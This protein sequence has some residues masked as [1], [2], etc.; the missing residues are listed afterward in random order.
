MSTTTHRLKTHPAAFYAVRDGLKPFEVRRNDR[1]F[2]SGDLVEL[3]YWDP[4]GE[5]NW[6]DVDK[7]RNN[8]IPDR[9]TKRVGWILGGG[10]YGIEPGYVAFALEPVDEVKAKAEVIRK[11]MPPSA[12]VLSPKSLERPDLQALEQIKRSLIG[13][14]VVR[15]LPTPQVLMSVKRIC[16]DYLVTP[17][18]LSGKSRSACH[19]RPR[20][21]LM[22]VLTNQHGWSSTE[23]GDLIGG[24]DHTTVL[25]GVKRHREHMEEEAEA[26]RQVLLASQ[27]N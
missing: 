26:E 16:D 18:L 15:R 23:I 19:V 21:K 4:N 24:R 6:E 10:Q 25:H 9:I 12:R 14:R 7:T 5:Q 1:L 27:S 2:Q 20:Q 13:V 3:I 8:L 11:L 22:Y 17:E